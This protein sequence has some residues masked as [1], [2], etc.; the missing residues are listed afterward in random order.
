[1]RCACIDIGTNTTRLLVA[2]EDHAGALRVLAQERAFTELGDADE[3]GPEKTRMLADAVRGQAARARE[4]QTGRLRVVATGALREAGDRE[5]V[6]EALRDAGGAEVELLSGHEEAT[7]AFT[8][9]LST[10]RPP[11]DGVVAVVDVGGGSSEVAVGRAGEGVTWAGS[12]PVG[13]GRLTE[14]FLLSD[15][16][17]AEELAAAR[18]HARAAWE[19]L[20]ELPGSDLAVAVGGS[21]ASLPRLVGERLDEEA[22]ARA[23]EL[24]TGDSSAEVAR[25]FELDPR[26]V[27]LLP[28]GLVVLEAAARR[29][30]RALEVGRGGLREGVVLAL[31]ADT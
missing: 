1:M 29:L 31:M 10:M 9:A 15:P 3:V 13:S 14:R 23:L 4:L 7:L 27:R 11:P 28:A 22:I 21:A 24:L 16:P 18:A 30:G 25:V 19:A 17:S 12:M 26:R 2:E 6:L 20:G 8:G 5:A